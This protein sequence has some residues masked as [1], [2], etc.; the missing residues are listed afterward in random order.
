MWLL[1]AAL[2]DGETRRAETKGQP[3][4]SIVSKSLE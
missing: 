2:M 4:E 3:D 1:I